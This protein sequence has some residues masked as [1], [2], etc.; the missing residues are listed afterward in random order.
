MSTTPGP[1]SLCCGYSREISLPPGV[2]RQRESTSL[3][4]LGESISSVGQRVQ[5]SAPNFGGKSTSSTSN[6]LLYTSPSPRD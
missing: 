1:K 5:V 3:L 2:S 6:C 4:K